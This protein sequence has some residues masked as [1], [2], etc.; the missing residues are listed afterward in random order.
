MVLDCA[1]M[2]ELPN[3]Q[4]KA[5]ALKEGVGSHSLFFKRIGGFL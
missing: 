1:S 5:I 2:D 4:Q 3:F